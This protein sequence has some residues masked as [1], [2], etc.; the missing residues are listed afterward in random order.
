MKRFI[1]GS[2]CALM[3]CTACDDGRIYEQTYTA[4]EGKTVVLTGTL[5]GLDAWA[6]GYSVSI[7]GFDGVDDYAFISKVLMPRQDGSLHIAD[8]LSGIPADVRNVQLCVI[9]RLRQHVV[10]FSEVDVT[11]YSTRDTIR[12]DVGT[13][14]VGMFQAIQQSY[15][16]TTC[17][18]CHGATGRAAAG[19]FLTEGQSYDALVG[20][21]SHKVEGQLLV[22]AGQPDS[23]I[24]YQALTTDLTKDWREYHRDLVSEQVELK[25]LP[26]IRAWIQGGAEQ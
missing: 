16:N 3:L 18:N 23:S 13:I 11:G 20:A 25:I 6:D 17:A 26:I 2:F 19:L 1:I 8:T 21:A 5:Q 15:F 22:K 24:L 14:N 10:T 7:A 9:N 12:M 4:T